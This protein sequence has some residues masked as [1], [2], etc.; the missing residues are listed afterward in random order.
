VATKVASFPLQDYRARFRVLA[1][2]LLAVFW[3]GSYP[4]ILGWLGAHGASVSRAETQ[5]GFI[6]SLV[7]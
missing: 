5:F 1:T 6:H 3:T 7:Q 2:D 4:F